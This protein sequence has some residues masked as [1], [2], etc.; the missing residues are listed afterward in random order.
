MLED[1]GEL[2]LQ[3]FRCRVVVLMHHNV[4]LDGLAESIELLGLESLAPAGH[5]NLAIAV[6]DMVRQHV[7]GAAKLLVVSHHQTLFPLIFLSRFLRCDL[8]QENRHR[9]L[10]AIQEVNQGAGDFYICFNNFKFF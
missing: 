4:V 5:L 3:R 7:D 9:V 10:V 6:I 8:G 1:A 2:G